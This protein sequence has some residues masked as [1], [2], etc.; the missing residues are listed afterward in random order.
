MYFPFYSIFNRFFII[1]TFFFV[2]NVSYIIIF[3]FTVNLK[4]PV[5]VSF[6][7]KNTNRMFGIKIY[8][9][10]C[11]LFVFAILVFLQNIQKPLS[12][13]VSGAGIVCAEYFIFSIRIQIKKHS[14]TIFFVNIMQRCIRLRQSDT[15]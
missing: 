10:T 1:Q 4:I 3:C 7:Q 5:T 11:N 8:R 9:I 12:I 2:I 15:F 14:R 13:A 6:F